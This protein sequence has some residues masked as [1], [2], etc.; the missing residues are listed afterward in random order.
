MMKAY[1]RVEWNYLHGCLCKLGFDPT[2]I[3]SVMRCVTCVRYA[4]RVNGELTEPVVPSRGIRQGDPISPYLFL[5]CTEGLSSLLQQKEG[6]GELYG[7][8]NG[9]L[10]P[11][12]SHLLFADDSIFFARSDDRSVDALKNTLKVYCEGSGQKNNLEKSSVFFGDHCPD[13]VKQKVKTSLEVQSEVLNDF[14]LGMPTSVGR[15]PTATFNFLYDKI[16]KYINGLSGRPLSRSGNEA[17]LKAVIQAIPTFVMSCFQ[18]PLTTCDK[19]KSVI[20]NRWWGEEDG[21]K[22]IHWRSWA[23]LST[24]KALG[25]MGFRDLGLFNQQCLPSRGGIFLLSQILSVCVC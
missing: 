10:G 12:I 19:M 25:G 21:K 3:Q 8:R 9:R 16:W 6:R 13:Q 24:P 17:L 15:S 2:W 11:P 7:I 23:W 14:Y 18:L 5:L 4:V 1:D 22:K 20:A